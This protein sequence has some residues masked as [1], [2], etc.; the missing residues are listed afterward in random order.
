MVSCMSML[1]C[2]SKRAYVVGR[3]VLYVLHGGVMFDFRSI[4]QTGS[5]DFLFCPNTLDLYRFVQDN[6]V[7]DLCFGLR[8]M[9]MESNVCQMMDIGL[10][11]RCILPHGKPLTVT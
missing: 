8:H 2:D 10:C 11:K 3:T 4:G 9:M 6:V 1:A 5:A 7:Y